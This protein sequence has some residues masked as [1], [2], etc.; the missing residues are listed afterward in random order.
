MRYCFKTYKTAD[1]LYLVKKILYEIKRA[2]EERSV[3]AVAAQ[4]EIAAVIVKFIVAREKFAK[5]RN[6]RLKESGH[7]AADNY[8]AAQHHAYIMYADRKMNQVIIQQLAIS[9]VARIHACEKF[10]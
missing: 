7:E 5:C 6:I 8:V 9:S 4:A 1:C 2:A 3:F 10:A